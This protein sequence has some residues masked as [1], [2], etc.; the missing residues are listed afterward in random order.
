M[1][2]ARTTQLLAAVVALAALAPAEA[3]AVWLVNRSGEACQGTKNGDNQHIAEMS[4]DGILQ[5]S[6]SQGQYYWCR[7]DVPDAKYIDEINVYGYDTDD[8]DDITLELR[9]ASYSA[10]T[11]TRLAGWTSTT[12]QT[13]WSAN[14]ATT[15]E[16]V[17]RVSYAYYL[18]IHIPSASNRTDFEVWNYDVKYVD[19]SNQC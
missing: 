11:T 14:E 16:S 5:A 13:T 19:T 12:D 7:I 15:C 9:R 2:R 6:L 3:Y 8:G 17:N 18:Y 10:R 4:D 1:S